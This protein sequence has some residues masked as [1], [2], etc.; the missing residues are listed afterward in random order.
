MLCPDGEGETALSQDQPHERFGLPPFDT[1]VPNPARMW[2]YWLGGKDNFAADRTAADRVLEVM[3]SMPTTA[4]MVRRFLIDAVYRLAKDYGIRQFLDIGTGLPTADNTHEVAQRTAAE[5]R[6]VYVDYDSVVLSHA[7]ALL[8]SSAEG[9][10]D[11]VQADL[12]DTDTILA[13]AAQTLDF[14]RPVAVLLIAVLHFIPDAD[15]PHAVVARLMAAMPPGSYLAIV[16]GSSDIQAD[17]T[18]E[19]MRLNSELT[20][21]S[22]TL[23]TYE[24]VARFF[25]GMDLVE[26]G[27]VSISR[28]WE[29]GQAECN[30]PPSPSYCGIGRKIATTS[31]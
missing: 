24:Q 4:R 14:S 19:M 12:R 22:L 28:W 8:T 3:P 5:S 15:D 23:R 21:V 17:A 29:P 11:Y 20:Q 30:I 27:L 25:D 13:Q 9:K 31:M 26:P 2:N 10:T 18:A 7:R 16:H 1:R 6:I